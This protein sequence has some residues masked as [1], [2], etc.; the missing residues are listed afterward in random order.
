MAQLET[1]LPQFTAGIVTYAIFVYLFVY[2][3]SNKG[4][5]D[6]EKCL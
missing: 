5:T 2:I 3:L 1:R 4:D 6:K